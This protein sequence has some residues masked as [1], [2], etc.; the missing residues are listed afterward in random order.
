MAGS[1]KKKKNNCTMNGVLRITSMYAL[2]MKRSQPGPEVL[3]QAQK[4][5]TTSP[6]RVAMSES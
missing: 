6:N 5:A 1:A 4:M 3:P 2:T